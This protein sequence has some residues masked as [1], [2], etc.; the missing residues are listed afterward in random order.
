MKNPKEGL[1]TYRPRCIVKDAAEREE[2]DYSEYS[3]R[4]TDERTNSAG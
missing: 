3:A 4:K 1:C 2:I